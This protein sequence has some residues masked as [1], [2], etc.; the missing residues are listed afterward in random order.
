METFEKA[1]RF[2]YQ[3]ARPVD[4]ARWQ[5]H[6]E[7]GSKEAVM[8]ALSA[9]QNPDGGFGNEL[10]ADN[11]NPHSSPMQTWQ[12][13]NIIGEIDFHGEH[14]V[15]SGM[16]RYLES[17]EHFDEEHR[18]WLNTIPS[19]NDYPHAIWW[20]YNGND[21]FCYN[22]TAALAA[23]ILLH[24]PKQSCL[25]AKGEMLA[26]EAVSFFTKSAIAPEPHVTSCFIELYNALKEINA[27]EN[28]LASLRNAIS[29]SIG[30]LICRDTS[31]WGKE[32]VSLPSTFISGTD[33]EFIS[34]YEELC[35]EECDF[36]IASQLDDGSYP[37][38]WQWCNDYKEVILADNFW[39]SVIV[40]NNMRFLR[41][42]KKL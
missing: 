14:P 23:F 29:D 7:N 22:P 5:H 35:L 20:E 42:M 37:I 12:A 26:K 18:Q 39:K 25:Y 2:I 1:R 8:N 36:I 6:F 27:P 9:Y 15:I 32:Y 31:K 24:S 28:E 38:T 33:S 11:F 16:L 41:D 17:G 4:L 19:N 21:P 40:M 34:G 10:E 13:A 30:K 3:N